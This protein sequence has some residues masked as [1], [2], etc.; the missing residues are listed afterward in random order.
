MKVYQQNRRNQ[1]DICPN[2][3]LFTNMYLGPPARGDMLTGKDHFGFGVFYFRKDIK[4]T[5][6]Y[7]LYNELSMFAEIGGYVGLLLGFSIVQIA[8]V[9]S[10]M[11]DALTK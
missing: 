7:Q 1:M 3:C 2:S 8:E 5:T 9:F 10:K 11:I 4:R 6:E